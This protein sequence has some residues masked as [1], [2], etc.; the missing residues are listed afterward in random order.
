[1]NPDIAK[2]KKKLI[3]KNQNLIFLNILRKIRFF[4]KLAY[5][6]IFGANL[7]Q[8][9]GALL[10]RGESVY[11][12]RH[13]H[14]LETIV[15]DARRAA[16]DA[17]CVIANV[18]RRLAVAQ[19]PVHRV[20]PSEQLLHTVRLLLLDGGGALHDT[21]DLDELGI[22]DQMIRRVLLLNAHM[23]ILIMLL[24]VYSSSASFMLLLVHVEFHFGVIWRRWVW[25]LL[26]SYACATRGPTCFKSVYK[27]KK[28]W[29]I[30]FVSFQ[31]AALPRPTL[32]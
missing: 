13:A 5:I 15:A 4:V 30:S 26:C 29:C 1:M 7:A 10:G 9:D 18:A 21:L 8:P 19:G 31:A 22:A 17:E 6:S 20:V 11:W 24:I 16:Q 3:K 25:N 23:I 32:L 2:I 28:K 12:A 27:N 14:L